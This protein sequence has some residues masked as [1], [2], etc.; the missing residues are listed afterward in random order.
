MK[1]IYFLIP[2]CLFLFSFDRVPGNNSDYEA[3]IMYREDLKNSIEII[4][5]V[6]VD[7]S[8]KIYVYNEM[9]FMTKRYEGIHVISN[10]DPEKP[11]YLCF[12]NVPGCQDI[13]IKSDI[14]YTDNSTDLVAIDISAL[15]NSIREV[16]RIERAFPNPLP[17]DMNEIPRLYRAYNRP[18]N[19]VIV[20]WKL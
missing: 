20:G 1:P 10:S 3:I 7:Q 12:I 6:S 18:K 14:L 5:S 2:L 13:S 19:T 9:V 15:P 16:K 8:G 11:E 17:P 4:D